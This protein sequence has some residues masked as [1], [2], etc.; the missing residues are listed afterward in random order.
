MPA[1]R[2]AHLSWRRRAAMALIGLGLHAGSQAQLPFAVPL[3]ASILVVPLLLLL[4]GLATNFSKRD[5]NL[6]HALTDAHDWAG[7]ERLATQRLEQ[8]PPTAP[9]EEARSG[10]AE[11]WLG[12]RALARQR[13]GQYAGAV[14]DHEAARRLGAEASA[15]ADFNR[16]LCLMA[17]GRWEAAAQAMQAVAQ[18]T[19]EAWAPWYS[20]G[21]IRALEGN[22]SGAQ[23]ALGEL[24][25]RN[26]GQAAAYEHDFLRVPGAAATLIAGPGAPGDNTIS[27]AGRVLTLPSQHWQPLSTVSSTVTG[28]THPQQPHL[29]M[30]PVTAL[31]ASAIAIDEARLMGAVRA[32]LN[33][34]VSLGIS[35]WNVDRCAASDAIHLDRF[36]GRFDT[37]ECLSVRRVASVLPATHGAFGQAISGAVERGAAPEPDYF[38]FHYSLYG[39]DRFVRIDLLLPVRAFAGDLV[40]IDWAQTLASA[41]RPLVNQGASA[42]TVPTPG[43]WPTPPEGAR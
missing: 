38:E 6:V 40:A 42:A 33:R 12:V 1:H 35:T 24:R 26:P 41:M 37:P 39:I 13:L 43:R 36:A 3:P 19:P 18:A 16:G 5:A 23:Q 31:T 9:A 21:V 25:A 2:F 29:M 32:T 27:I 4:G 7:L 11:H 22:A 30:T 17:L 28:G 8:R 34:P 10:R 15:A 14:E 20:L